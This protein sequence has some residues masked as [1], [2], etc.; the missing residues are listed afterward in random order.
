MTEMDSDSRKY[1]HALLKISHQFLSRSLEFR[2]KNI[3]LV[4]FSRTQFTYPTE[5][6]DMH[7]RN[8]PLTKFKHTYLH[9][10]NAYPLSHIIVAGFVFTLHHVPHQLF[11]IADSCPYH[12]RPLVRSAIQSC[13][14]HPQSQYPFFFY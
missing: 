1:R 11:N 8:I 9:K 10:G 2:C 4:F 5:N 7:Q 12:K 13:Q 3:F 14:P 6:Y